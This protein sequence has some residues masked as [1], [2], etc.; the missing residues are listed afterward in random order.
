VTPAASAGFRI[1]EAEVIFWGLCPDCAV[2][3]AA[4]A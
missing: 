4:A 2:S 1:D 3:P